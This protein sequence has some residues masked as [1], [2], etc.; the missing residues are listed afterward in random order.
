M[1]NLIKIVKLSL[2]VASSLSVISGTV[3]AQNLLERD[4]IPFASY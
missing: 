2:V 1:N 3:M 4:P